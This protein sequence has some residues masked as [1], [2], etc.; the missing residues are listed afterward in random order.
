MYRLAVNRNRLGILKFLDV[1]LCQFRSVH[2]DGQLVELAGKGKWR[3]VVSVIDAGQGVGANVEA[4]VPLEDHGK[5]AFH[6]DSLDSLAV[7]LESA[8]A[9]TTQ[10]THIVEGERAYPQTVILEVEFNC[11][12][13]RSEFRSFPPDPFEVDQVPQEHGLAL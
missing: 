2:L 5:C 4:L 7:H 8:G 3:L 12:P 11:V 9:G 10:A 13:A 1:L 6:G